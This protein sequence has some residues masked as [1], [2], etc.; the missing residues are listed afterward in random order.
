MSSQYMRACFEQVTG[1]RGSDQNPRFNPT[2][3]I[4]Y[5]IDPHFRIRAIT[6]GLPG[7]RVRLIGAFGAS[8]RGR[9]Q[10]GVVVGP[11]EP[12]RGDSW[13]GSY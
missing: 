11:A 6:L 1:I 8:D 4:C 12:A 9:Y 7:D 3:E 2:R 5:Y 10:G 13:Y